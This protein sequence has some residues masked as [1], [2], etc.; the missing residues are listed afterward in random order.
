MRQLR[1]LLGGR[2]GFGVL[3]LL[4]IASAVY[5]VAAPD[6]QGWRLGVVLFQATIVVAAVLT[7]R[8]RRVVTLLL[9]RWIWC[10]G[11]P[12]RS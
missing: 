6:E 8:R 12:P 7:P 5:T 1:S 10:H 4:V 2:H 9:T 3:L 11:R